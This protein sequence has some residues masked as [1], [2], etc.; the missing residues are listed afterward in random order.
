MTH[1]SND[2][3][4]LAAEGDDHTPHLRTCDS[5][6][7]RV[8]E[9]RRVLQLTSGVTVPEP[10]PLFWTHFSDRVHQAVAAEPAPRSSWR[11]NVAWTASVSGA[12]AIIVIGV[13]VTLRTAQPVAPV[14]PVASADIPA[15]GDSLPSLSDDPTW[16]LMGELASQIDWEDASEAG[17][18]ARPGSA[19]LAL[20][21]MSADERRQ[22][23]ELLQLELQKTKSL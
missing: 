15:V 12:L 22:V 10:S 21:Q 17:L 11:F 3:L 6:R 19:E 9:L 5:C 18:I 16:A 1:L 8:D 20:S 2:E 13:A 7:T 4:L 23:I 14:V